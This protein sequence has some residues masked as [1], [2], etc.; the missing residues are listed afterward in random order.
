MLSR[1]LLLGFGGALAILAT[2]AAISY[3]VLAQSQFAEA[4]ERHTQDAVGALE[5]LLSQVV[6]AETAQRG[7]LLTG[8]NE[9]LRPYRR[10]VLSI[11]KSME[12]L[13]ALT[14]DDPGA[15]LQMDA[16]G[17]RLG[18]LLTALEE[19]IEIRRQ[20]GLDGARQPLA[21]ER[22]RRAMDDL[23]EAIFQLQDRERGA[24]ADND[25]GRRASAT[26]VILIIVVGNLA[27]FLLLAGVFYALNKENAERR[28]A[29]L[30]AERANSAKS[31]FL[32]RM[33]H[34]LRT[35]LNAILGFAQLLEMD[36]LSPPQRENVE[37]ILA[38]GHHLLKLINEILDISRIESDHLQLSPEAV[39]VDTLLRE[40]L[41]LIHP[42]A[43]EY[44]VQAR[45]QFSPERYVRADHQRLKQV[46]LN[47]LTNA[48]KY[49]RRGGTAAVTYA[50]AGP[51]RL[52]ISV[53]DTGPGISQE[54]RE[55]LFVPFD[56]LGA[57][58]QGIEGTGL[59]LVLSRRLVQAMDGTLGVE[60]T[61]GQGSNFW[62]DLPSVAAPAGQPLPV[63]D[64]SPPRLEHW[65][66]ARTVL[67]IEDNLSNLR[68]IERALSGQHKVKLMPAMQ[69]R[70]GLDLARQ[71]RPDLI[72]L[73]L[74][75]PDIHGAEV[76][77]RLQADPSTR[78]IPVVVI[79][80][81]ATPGQIRRLRAAGA[82]DYLTKPVD[83]AKLFRL[84]DDVFAA[85]PRE[86][87]GPPV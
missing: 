4:E 55:R 71:H 16:M 33:S 8:D 49:N 51:G 43:A 63:L 73:D 50:D 54:M 44:G 1:R 12:R 77:G 72:L 48:V 36:D 15:S 37:P 57:E 52:R 10:A 76:L 68:L 38:G 75:L 56:R 58:R 41:D 28:R 67:Y 19:S 81:D 87:I 5:R 82:H 22:S 39:G 3:H 85:R 65:E 64:P 61:V 9:V 29:E 24:L 23:R 14:A 26:R 84:L 27:S 2:I 11:Y 79:S 40:T 34:E 66:P 74:H 13:R 59:G 21:T 80:A 17:P 6:E 70:I 30:A 18:V 25:A 32:S 78:D 46:L 53:T 69:G 60:S 7:F 86:A 20:K 62:V 83:V 31:E 47:L 42:L 35:P 45:G